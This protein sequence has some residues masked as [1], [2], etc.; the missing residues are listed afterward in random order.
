MKKFAL[1]TLVGLATVYAAPAISAPVVYN[2]AL[3]NLGVFDNTVTGTGAPL[4][5]TSLVNGQNVY[6]YLDSNGNAQTVT[7]TRTGTGAAATP[8]GGYSSNGVSLSGS[9]IDISPSNNGGPIPGF[10]SGVTFTFSSGV[11]AFGFEVGDWATCCLT[12]ARS[13]SVQSTYGVPAQGSGLWIA[14][15]G[16]AATL[17]ANALNALD[18]PGVAAQNSFTNFIGAIDSSSTFTSITF[19]GDGF[20]EFLVIG[21]SLR[22]SAVPLNSVGVPEPATYAL[23]G[24]GLAGLGLARRRKRA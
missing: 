23:L 17:P 22:F 21:G 12:N 19:F 4:L 14:F 15:D 5:V 11:N 24:L 2:L 3:N 18:N 1:A 16:G 7:I 20:G 13:A 8:S 6:N 9:V 10:N